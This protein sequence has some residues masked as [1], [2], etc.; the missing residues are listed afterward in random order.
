MLDDGINIFGVISELLLMARWTMQLRYSPLI[1][2]CGA[3]FHQNQ[4]LG[5]QMGLSQEREGSS[6][7]LPL[8]SPWT[9]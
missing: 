4:T 7:S 1:E 9:T 2:V 8:S 6:A 3:V 5:I